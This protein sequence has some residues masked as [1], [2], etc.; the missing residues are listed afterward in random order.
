MQFVFL[1]VCCLLGLNCARDFEANNEQFDS[2]KWK[3]HDLRARGRMANDLLTRGLLEGKS[4]QEVREF[5]GEPDNI[6][7]AGVME[8]KTDPG[9]WLGGANNGPWIHYLNIE[10]GN[11][12]GHVARAYITD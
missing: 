2:V 5:L 8:Y 4:P 10:Y 3:L 9:A 11:E 1:A 6:T 7:H 12:D